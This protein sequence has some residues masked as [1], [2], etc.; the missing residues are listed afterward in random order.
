MFGLRILAVKKPK[1]R[2]AVFSS[3]RNMAGSF[4]AQSRKCAG[5]F[6]GDDFNVHCIVSS[7]L[8]HR[9]R[10]GGEVIPVSAKL[11]ALRSGLQIISLSCWKLR[12]RSIACRSSR[13]RRL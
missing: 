5:F 7:G 10:T 6:E 11:F 4:A 2:S 12:I 1:N 8:I 13:P 9:P 3:G